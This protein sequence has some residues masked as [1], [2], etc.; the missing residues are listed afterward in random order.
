M[1]QRGWGQSLYKAAWGQIY[2]T[3]EV[4]YGGK[5]YQYYDRKNIDILDISPRIPYVLVRPEYKAAYSYFV[6]EAEWLLNDETPTR[7]AFI[8]T[9]QSGIGKTTFLI[10]LLIKRLQD[11]KPTAVQMNS[12]MFVLFSDRGVEYHSTVG[13]T[14][15][16]LPLGTWALTD[17][18]EVVTLP[19]TP[20]LQSRATIIQATS[21]AKHRWKE[22][23][24]QHEA[25]LYIMEPWGE[26]EFG[27][28]LTVLKWDVTRGI[29]FIRDFG[30]CPRIVLQLLR[31]YWRGDEAGANAVNRHVDAVTTAANESAPHLQRTLN[32]ISD[33]EFGGDVALS[34]LFFVRP[35]ADD[36]CAAVVYIPTVKLSRI[37]AHAFTKVTVNKRAKVF[38]SLQS[39]R[40]GKSAASWMY[41][42]YVHATLMTRNEADI[43]YAVDMDGRQYVLP[44]ANEPISATLRDLGSATPPFYWCPADPTFPGID[45]IIRTDDA[46]WAIQATIE[47]RHGS[48]QTG[49]DK[50]AAAIGKGNVK[51][52]YVVIVGPELERADAVRRDNL[53]SKEWTESVWSG[54]PIYTCA[55]PIG[56]GFE[57]LLSENEPVYIEGNESV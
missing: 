36:R 26:G 44:A 49:L 45:S 33:L 21:P 11:K 15:D 24:K 27:A 43:I 23:G 17:S 8:L 32:A 51:A 39:H 1:S 16:V 10:D 12:D 6:E 9:G 25:D 20:F 31:K 14:Y 54:I 47:S 35:R 29:Q 46:V 2:P 38:N 28:L 19:C 52:W 34:S 30:P 42:N 37:L 53:K 56:E 57:G 4:L 50:I 41:E 18:S 13:R 55:L 5:M 3:D 7:P 22:W 40:V 48:V